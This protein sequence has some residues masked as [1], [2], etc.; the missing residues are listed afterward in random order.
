MKHVISILALALAGA[1]GSAQAAPPTGQLSVRDVTRNY[2]TAVPPQ[3]GL[4][5]AG[6]LPVFT[7]VN[8][9]VVLPLATWVDPDGTNWYVQCVNYTNGSP[10]RCMAI[11]PVDDML[12]LVPSTGLSSDGMYVIT[13][14]KVPTTPVSDDETTRRALMTGTF[15]ALYG[16]VLGQLGLPPSAV[17]GLARAR[18]PGGAT[19]SAT[20]SDSKTPDEP[21]PAHRRGATN[22][23][24]PNPEVPCI[25][26][27]GHLDDPPD[28]QPSPL[29]SEPPAN[30]PPPGGGGENGG[31]GGGG[32]DTPD[33]SMATWK[34]AI[35]QTCIVA[36]IPGGPPMPACTV[37]ITAPKPQNP[38][39]IKPPPPVPF[40]WCKN[41][42][43]CDPTS[44]SPT[45]TPGSVL[46]G[47]K[48]VVDSAICIR[49]R[50]RLHQTADKEKQC[51]DLKYA[52]YIKC[53]A[54]LPL[55]ATT[56]S[57]GATK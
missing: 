50:L 33:G 12:G 54:T 26:V 3:H 57:S 42:G 16:Q 13:Y 35:T 5:V 27:T 36:P 40:D 49:D 28:N 9:I 8:G 45:P 17:A 19:R 51:L 34:K 14:F 20:G 10:Q 11:I 43:F 37:V 1:F 30:N 23:C 56:A 15:S 21:D 4:P 48:W 52:D 2:A 55:R 22:N 25:P 47:S 53:R 32:S 41:A 38:D 31:G 46:C 18:A 29:P 44:Q 6:T 7:S 39:E 24:D